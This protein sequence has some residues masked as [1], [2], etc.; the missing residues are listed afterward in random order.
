MVLVLLNDD[1]LICLTGISKLI[2]CKLIQ[3]LF[4]KFEN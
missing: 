4:S 2:I 1:W 3:D